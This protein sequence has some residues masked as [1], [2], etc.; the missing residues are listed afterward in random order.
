MTGDDWKAFPDKASAALS[1]K[2]GRDRVA[3]VFEG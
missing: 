3:G 1:T 2:E